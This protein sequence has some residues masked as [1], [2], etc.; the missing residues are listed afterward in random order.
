MKLELVRAVLKVLTE[1]DVV[2]RIIELLE[3][4]AK[5]TKNPID[6]EII[7]VLKTLVEE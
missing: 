1:K 3:M 7:K 6:D 5:E 4:L 2:L